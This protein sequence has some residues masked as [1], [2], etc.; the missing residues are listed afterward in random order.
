MNR[1]ELLDVLREEHFR[2]DAYSLDGGLP[3]ERY[4]L[5]EENGVWVV[6]YSERGVQS[7]KT[8]FANECDACQY[9]LKLLNDDPTTGCG[10]TA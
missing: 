9:L 2:P 6:Y 3:D 8:Q 1:T 10:S 7:G 5:G 4:C